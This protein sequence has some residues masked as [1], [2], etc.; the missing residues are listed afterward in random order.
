M[1]AEF[2][3]MFFTV[4]VLTAIAAASATLLVFSPAIAQIP[5]EEC[6]SEELLADDPGCEACIAQEGRWI[7]A[8][9]RQRLFCLMPMADAGKSCSDGAQCDS[10]RCQ[11]QGSDK[12]PTEPVVGTCA[13][14]NNPYGCG[15]SVVQGKYKRRTCAD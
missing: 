7:R 14:D 6:R 11:Y 4:R 5:T 3:R 10:R 12:N 2:S 13:A 9:L 8:G 1:S 15:K